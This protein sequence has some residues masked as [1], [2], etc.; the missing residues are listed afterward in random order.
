MRATRMN[1]G[2]TS[3]EKRFHC[4]YERPRRVDD[5]VHNQ[6]RL[7]VHITDH[8]H[9]LGNVSFDSPLVHDRQFGI[10]AFCKCS[11]AFHAAGVRRNHRQILQIQ[12]LKVLHQNRRREQVIDRDAEEALDLWS[13][14]VHCKQPI[15][16]RG[17]EQVRNDFR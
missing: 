12:L 16:T 11:G 10:Q 2:R 5:V 1:F 6:A 7:A 14:Q 17:D 4:L 8:V 3:F 15:G 13:M 9:H